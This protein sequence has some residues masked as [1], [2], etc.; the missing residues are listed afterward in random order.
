[1]VA[2]NNVVLR[3]ARLVVPDKAQVQEI[4][5][6]H[7]EHQGVVKAKQFIREIIWFTGSDRK[8]EEAVKNCEVCQRTVV[9]RARHPL[10]AGFSGTL[11]GSKYL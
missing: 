8:V 11:P 3:G 7:R 9:E 1:M 2:D 6:A 4:R 5:L 10:P